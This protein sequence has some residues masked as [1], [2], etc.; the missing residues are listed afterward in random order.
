[1]FR[2]MVK[3]NVICMIIL[4]K[5]RVSIRYPADSSTAAAVTKRSRYA[6][7]LFHEI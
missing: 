1:M 3:T 2:R 5:A 6:A 7:L 4:V